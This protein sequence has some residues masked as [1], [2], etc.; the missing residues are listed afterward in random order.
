MGEPGRPPVPPLNLVA[1]FGGCAM[2]LAV[3]VL[4]ALLEAARSGR[5]QV[6]DAAMIDGSTLLMTMMYELLGRQEW[7]TGRGR[8][9]N[10]GGAPY[11]RTYET[12][13]GRYLAVGAMEPRF[14]DELVA[15]LG[16]DPASTR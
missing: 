3:G 14:Y 2:L 1:D 10:D 7:V 11:Y 5:G 12:A 16:R 8:T 15:R 6:V 9:I 13:D 4:A